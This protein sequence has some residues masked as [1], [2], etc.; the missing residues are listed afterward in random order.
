MSRKALILALL[1]LA[2]LVAGVVGQYFWPNEPLSAADYGF[3]V[4]G[5]FLI[6]AWYHADAKQRGYR[7]SMWLNI[8]VILLALVAMPYYFFRTRGFSRG[9]LATVLGLLLMIGTSVVTG[10]GKLA[11]YL[12]FQA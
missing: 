12:L 4:I 5:A 11:T 3:A 2:S 7:R 10:L 8:G 6:F 1:V 9:L